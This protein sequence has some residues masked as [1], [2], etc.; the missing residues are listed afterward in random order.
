MLCLVIFIHTITVVSEYTYTFYRY[1][2]AHR[3]GGPGGGKEG[4]EGG[5]EHAHSLV[6]NRG[7]S[8]NWLTRE[9][10]DFF[11]LFYLPL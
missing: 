6:G 10:S 9:E 4:R 2:I 3:E 5:K 7:D 11:C 8:S 1:I